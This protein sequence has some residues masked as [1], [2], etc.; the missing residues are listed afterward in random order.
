MTIHF[1]TIEMQELAVHRAGYA[2][3]GGSLF[4]SEKTHSLA[5]EWLSGVLL[6]FFLKPFNEAEQYI[7]AEDNN[8]LNIIV[9]SFFQ[10]KES[11]DS[12]SKAIAT[13]LHE[14]SKNGLIKNGEIYIASF[15]KF[16]F[17]D[18]E[19]EAIGIFHTAQKEPF[20]KISNTRETINLTV[21]EGIDIKKPEKGFIAINMPEDARCLVFEAGIQKE[22]NSFWK[23]QFLQ[24]TPV[25]NS[26]H[27]TKAALGMCKLF[28]SNEISEQFET[29]KADEAGMLQRS[30][31]YFKT[32]DSFELQDFSKE[33]LHHPELIESFT[34]YKQQY[35]VAKQVQIEDS[36]DINPVAVQQQQ[37]FFKSIL[38]LDKNFHV[39][40]HGRRDLIEKG[41]DQQKGKHFYKLYFD[42]ETS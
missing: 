4:L 35:E 16:P 14:S 12:I 5:D 18:Q 23:K 2:A 36:F 30:M 26:Y 21:E 31:E 29:D 39:Y 24:V 17:H 38:K 22:E 8:P 3:Q 34:Q 27:H 41:F 7:L 20:L 9:S 33:V 28:I 15:L 42:Q 19:Y 32:H 10:K 1:P 6:S 25:A 11:F 13:H 37:K 40:V